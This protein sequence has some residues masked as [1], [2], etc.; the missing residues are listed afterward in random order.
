MKYDYIIIG[1]GPTGL[2]LALYLSE[3]GWRCLL[4]DKNHSLGGCHRV[5]RQDGNYFTEHGPRIYS[6]AYTNVKEIL[7]MIGTSW[8]ETFV[9]YRFNISDI[10]GQTFNSL[11]IREK[12]LF[13]LEFLGFCIGLD[14]RRTTIGEFMDKN[15]FSDS[16]KD[17]IDRICRLTDGAGS[18]RYTLYQFLQLFNQNAF[19]KL[20][21]PRTPNDK[22]LFR[23]W[24]QKLTNN[25]VEIMKKCDV[26]GISDNIVHTNRGDFFGKRILLTIPPKPFVKLSKNS[27]LNGYTIYDIWSNGIGIPVDEWAEEVSYII[28]IPISF[29]WKKEVFLSKVW[30][31]P[32]D[33]WGI[34][35]IILTDYMK[36]DP[37]S[38]LV[39][40]TCITRVHAKS[41]FTGKSAIES[42]E[43]ELIDETFRQLKIS[44]PML[45][46]FNK[47]IVHKKT[48]TEEDTAYVETSKQY[49]MP[50]STPNSEHIYYIGTHNGKSHYAFTSMESAVVNAMYAINELEPNSKLCI[51]QDYKTV[52]NLIYLFFFIFIAVV[53]YI[54][55]SRKRV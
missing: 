33:D 36:P 43:K 29:H 53:L 26:M 42:T 45:P 32:R 7:K 21:Q 15:K 2:T 25:G 16:S 46:E 37:D 18:D 34:A 54:L 55:V 48:L 20:F 11:N 27:T 50:M 22:G 1:G 49:F 44:F 47:A 4:L 19:N 24:E 17:Y 5:T 52:N 41:K 28:D 8:D 6:S 23:L 3:L 12:A 9:P 38:G 30:G 14:K 10:Q 39:I 51:K 40:S 31:F 13:A 35:F